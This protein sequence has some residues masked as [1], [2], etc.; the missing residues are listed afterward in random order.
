MT[1]RS[2]SDKAVEHL[3]ELLLQHR[4]ARRVRRHDRLA[5][6]DEVAELAVLFLADRRLEAD[7]L[8]ADLEDLADALRGHL[9]LLADLLGRGLAAE[10]L[11]Q[12][13]AARG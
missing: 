2:R 7:R 1:L 12:A 3:R 8:L 9:H 11:Q 10:L 6:L 5:V 4:E 13:G